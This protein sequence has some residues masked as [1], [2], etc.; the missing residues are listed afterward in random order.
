VHPLDLYCTVTYETESEVTT[1]NQNEANTQP[2]SHTKSPT[3]QVR[4]LHSHTT[5]RPAPTE[6][7]SLIN[8]V[9]V[10]NLRLELDSLS[11]THHST[12]FLER[13]EQGTLSELQAEDSGRKLFQILP[14]NGILT[15]YSCGR[16]QGLWPPLTIHTFLPRSSRQNAKTNHEQIRHAY[17]AWLLRSRERRP[18]R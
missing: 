3:S 8:P 4:R 18:S 7:R 9:A 15:V 2:H 17:R 12:R 11:H 1:P 16:R 6:A 5:A 13:R 14:A 10:V